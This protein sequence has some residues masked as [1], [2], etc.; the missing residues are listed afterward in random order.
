M[1]EIICKH[2][3]KHNDE[4]NILT[5]FQH[6]FRRVRSC[7]TQLLTTFHYLLSYWNKDFQVDI[8][9]LHFLSKAFD[10]APHRL[11]G[12]LHHYGNNI[13]KCIGNFLKT[14]TQRVIM[15]RT[16]ADQVPIYLGVPQGTVLGPMLFLLHID[17]LCEM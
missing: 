15:D 9:L 6:G 13:N 17:D 7:E 2:I 16:K 3:T 10:T 1:K 8:I 12:K 11:L 5:P 14:K 4:H